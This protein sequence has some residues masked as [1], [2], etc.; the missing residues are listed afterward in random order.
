MAG[1]GPSSGACSSRRS[2]WSCAWPAVSSAS[3]WRSWPGAWAW[4][5]RRSRRNGARSLRGGGRGGRRREEAE[6]GRHRPRRDLVRRPSSR[7]D[8]LGGRPPPPHDT[9]P[10]RGTASPRSAERPF[11]WTEW[12][13]DAA[14]SGSQKC[15]GCPRGWLG[16]DRPSRAF[17]RWRH[18][19]VPRTAG[20]STSSCSSAT[21]A[22]TAPTTTRSPRRSS[23][24]CARAAA[25]RRGGPRGS[26][27][28]PPG[29][30]RDALGRP[31]GHGPRPARARS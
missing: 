11:S 26:V 29:E 16:D 22:G 25:R 19:P 20:T 17:R 28:A 8:G 23:T 18:A 27:G 3:E 9:L 13:L 30:R 7:W 4:R 31:R 12:G 6:S 21:G 2:G 5:S 1:N 14:Y 24:P 10:D 15:L